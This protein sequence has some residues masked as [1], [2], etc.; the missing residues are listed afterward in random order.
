MAKFGMFII[1]TMAFLFVMQIPRLNNTPNE[2]PLIQDG[3]KKKHIAPEDITSEKMLYTYI[4]AN[5]IYWEEH[6]W[7]LVN[8]PN[9]HHGT[10]E[11]LKEINEAF[12]E[13]SYP[14]CLNPISNLLK[15]HSS[16]KIKNLSNQHIQDFE[17]VVSRAIRE[18]IELKP[19]LMEAL[20]SCQLKLPSLL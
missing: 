5:I 1:L 20:V 6:I 17:V 16:E 14:E 4:T 8:K 10:I 12:N 19:K 13:V 3:T 7:H 11:S 15:K 2:T 9:E 18:K